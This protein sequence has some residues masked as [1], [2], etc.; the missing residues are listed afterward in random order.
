MSFNSNE[1][2]NG[3][4]VF[5]YTFARGSSLWRYTDQPED[6]VVDTVTY[7][8]AVIAHSD[9]QRDDESAAGTITV[10]MADTTPIVAALTTL[11]LQGLP[12]TCTIR[13]SH[14]ANVGDVVTPAS[15]VR[16]KGVVQGRERA[17]GRC[18]FTIA[19]LTG[20]F[21]RPLLRVLAAPTCQN[22]IY[23]G[24]CGV[25]PSLWQTAA[26]EV[27]AISGRTLTVAE[28]ALQADGYYTAAPLIVE[29]GTAVG[30]RLFVVTHVGDALTLA[31][32][33]PGTLAVG[34]HVSLFKGCQGTEAAC[35]E[36]SN[37]DWFMGFPRVP[38]V[39]P[40]EQVNP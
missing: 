10:T 37:I 19:S 30:E 23:D 20:A 25:D 1:L 8:A 16:Y 28:A 17:D 14:R 12:V 15:A 21:E 29:D 11:G 24:R 33:P 7:R 32:V 26:C 9:L 18:T 22:T 2:A 31:H 34:D 35:I 40:W 36:F 6:A 38:T 4:P 5:C 3:Q 39:N 13:Q 27:A